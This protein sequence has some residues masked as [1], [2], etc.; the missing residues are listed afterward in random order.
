MPKNSSRVV[1]IIQICIQH[2]KQDAGT[3]VSEDKPPAHPVGDFLRQRQAFMGADDYHVC[4]RRFLVR[5]RSQ[6]LHG[7]NFKIPPFKKQTS[8]SF[9]ILLD[10][11]QDFAGSR[12][13]SGILTGDN[14][15]KIFSRLIGRTV[16]TPQSK[17]HAG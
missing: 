15:A 2:C 17:V 9:D 14:H 5:Y 8:C 10:Q 13:D 1:Q 7:Q 16:W 4:L 11:F 3:V 12:G 6:R